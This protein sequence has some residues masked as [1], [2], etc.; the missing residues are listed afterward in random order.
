MTAPE[1]SWSNPV[2]STPVADLGAGL[3]RLRGQAQHRLLVEGE[4]AGALVQ[5]D[6][7]AG[8]APVAVQRAHVLGDLLLADVQLGRV[9]DPLLAFVDLDQIALLRRRT[10][11]DVAAAVVVERLRIRFPH[12]DAGRHQLGHR[13]LEVV[14]ADHA[15]RDPRRAG[16]DVG[17]VHDQHA[18]ALLREV[19]GGREAV[20]AGADD[21]DG[22]GVGEGFGHGGGSSVF[23]ACAQWH[24]AMGGSRLRCRVDAVKRLASRG[25]E[26]SLDTAL[27]SSEP[28]GTPY[29]PEYVFGPRAA[30]S[31][32]L[33]PC[34]PRLPRDS[35][36]DITAAVRICTTSPARPAGVWE[37][38][39]HRSVARPARVQERSG[40]WR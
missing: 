2:T 35:A 20:D 8:G 31:V 17:L 26:C 22:D 37:R 9:A 15:A 25:L 5:A 7:Q 30:S 11:R 12:L 16:G 10:E 13:R 33:W 28:F 1:L 21:E 18:L 32:R 29:A 40:G 23:V 4:P 39:W 14:V 34:R 38:P 3:L 27:G 24:C 6:G 36:T 19:P